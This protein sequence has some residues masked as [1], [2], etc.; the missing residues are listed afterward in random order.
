MFQL[1]GIKIRFICAG[2][3]VMAP[4]I[5]VEVKP[6]TEAELDSMIG[7]QGSLFSSFFPSVKNCSS[8]FLSHN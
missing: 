4:F 1:G 8:N 5:P 2:W 3:E 7:K 6:Y